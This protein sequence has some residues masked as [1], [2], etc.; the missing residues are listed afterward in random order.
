MERFS[1]QNINVSDQH[2]IDD[3]EY[4]S[5]SSFLETVNNSNFTIP[6]K[7]SFSFEKYINQLKSNFL[8]ALVRKA[9][10]RY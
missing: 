1:T 8:I 5:A 2:K 6:Y 10:L 9:L 4:F 7:T 3:E